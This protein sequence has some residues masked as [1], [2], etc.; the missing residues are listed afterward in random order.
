[1]PRLLRPEDYHARDRSHDHDAHQ[2]SQE[3]TGHNNKGLV[4]IDLSGIFTQPCY[5]RQDFAIDVLLFSYLFI[6]Y[7]IDL[8]I[9]ARGLK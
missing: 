5:Y 3:D 6:Y 1:M 7:S 4:L 8:F 9:I 2:C